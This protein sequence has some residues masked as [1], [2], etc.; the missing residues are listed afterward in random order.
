VIGSVG[1]FECRELRLHTRIFENR[2]P[3]RTDL[4]RSAV[5]EQLGSEISISRHPIEDRLRARR[6]HQIDHAIKELI[7]EPV[8]AIL[9]VLTNLIV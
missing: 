1:Q 2:D 8:D 7:G 5:F 6:I 4:S 3:W 9:I